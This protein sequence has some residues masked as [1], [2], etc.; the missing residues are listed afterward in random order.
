[1]N[2]MER[3]NSFNLKNMSVKIIFLFVFCLFLPKSYAANLVLED[4]GAGWAVVLGTNT[5]GMV[6]TYRTCPAL[7]SGCAQELGEFRIG[8]AVC[9]TSGRNDCS[10]RP[11]MRSSVESFFY[12]LVGM[13]IP[14]AKIGNSKMLSVTLWHADMQMTLMG[15]SMSWKE[16]KP[17]SCNVSSGETSFRHPTQAVGVLASVI[18]QDWTVACTGKV[19]LKVTTPDSVELK[20]ANSTIDSKLFVGEVGKTTQQVEVQEDTSIAL[21]SQLASVATA[22][23]E[24]SGSGVVQISWD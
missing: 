20:S 7:Q 8:S 4:I 9:S 23:G 16:S 3:I 11:Q 1:M 6:P 12:S 5:S 17:I 15:G 18:R 13:K 22:P 14:L 2:D 10:P 24:Y 21:L 19:S